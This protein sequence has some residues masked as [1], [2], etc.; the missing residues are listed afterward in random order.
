MPDI[1]VLEKE[2]TEIN[3]KTSVVTNKPINRF[4][5]DDKSYTKSFKE[6]FDSWPTFLRNIANNANNKNDD[7]EEN[8][9]E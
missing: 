5:E 4:P 8:K 3:S 1:D 2:Q 6:K 9:Q 7:N